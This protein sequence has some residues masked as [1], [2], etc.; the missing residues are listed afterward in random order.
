MF[1]KVRFLDSHLDFFHKNLGDVSDE[2][3][4]QFHQDMS[5][6]EIRYKR[7]WSVSMLADYCWSIR[8]DNSETQHKRRR[9]Y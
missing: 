5:V 9:H 3:G 4:K 2:H 6:I 8:H 1:L 7:K